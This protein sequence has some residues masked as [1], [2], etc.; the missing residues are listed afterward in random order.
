[1]PVPHPSLDCTLQFPEPGHHSPTIRLTLSRGECIACI[2][3][4]EPLPVLPIPGAS[5]QAISALD[6]VE[7]V[8]DE[9]AWL[10]EFCRVLVPG[11]KLVVRVPL[12]NSLAWADALNIYRYVADT[13]SRGEHPQE[14][15]P[16]GW[17]RHYTPRDLSATLE[18]AG[19]D[20]VASHGEGLPFDQIPHLAGLLVGNVVLQR[21]DSERRLFELRARHRMPERIPLPVPLATHLHLRARKIRLGYRPAPDLDESERP[22]EDTHT[23][24]E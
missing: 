4:S 12:E 5:I 7:H 19:F 14:T 15:I 10:A 2:P 13:L 16:T 17:H 1:M 3:T 22:E 6:I 20:V 11:G 24:L 18:Q 9:Q 8:H 23:P 21:S